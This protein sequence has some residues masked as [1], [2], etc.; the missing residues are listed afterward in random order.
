MVKVFNLKRKDGSKKLNLI[1]RFVEPGSTVAEF[2]RICEVQSDKASVEISSRFAGK[3]LKLHHGI[4]DIAKVGAPLVDIETDDDDNDET[5]EEP[6]VQQQQHQVQQE[7]TTKKENNVRSDNNGPV[8]ATPAVRK[9]AKDKGIDLASVVGTGKDGRVL[10][11]DVLSFGSVPEK[12][13]KD[14]AVSLYIHVTH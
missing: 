10:K 7:Q 6:V 8:L 11:E 9:L 12:Q 14:G 4:N 5:V 2:D 3:V 13:G 1:N